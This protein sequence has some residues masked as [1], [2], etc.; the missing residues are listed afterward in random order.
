MLWRSSR[1]ALHCR[2]FSAVDFGAQALDLECRGLPILE[3]LSQGSL[4][5]VDSQPLEDVGMHVLSYLILPS[6]ELHGRGFAGRGS[7][8]Y[9][10]GTRQQPR[11]LHFVR[12]WAQFSHSAAAALS[13]GLTKTGSSRGR[14]AD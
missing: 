3:Q 8:G 10:A 12:H 1:S 7:L 9:L 13:E 2:S 11:R 5:W 14:P 4:A 6:L